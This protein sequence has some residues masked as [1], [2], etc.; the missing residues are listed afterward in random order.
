M[1]FPLDFWDISLLTALAAIVLLITSELL[2]PYY[3]VVSIKINKKR[4][5][6][7]SIAFSMV[8]LVTVF[9]RIAGILL[10]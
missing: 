10:A 7:A 1:T 9:I 8:F 3:G 5:R 6:N 2:S 4:L